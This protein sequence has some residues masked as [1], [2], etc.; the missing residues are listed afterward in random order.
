MNERVT[1]TLDQLFQDSSFDTVSHGIRMSHSRCIVANGCFD[2]LHPGHLSLLAHLDTI[3]YERRLRP[4]VALNSDASIR[5]LKG[6][7]RPVVQQEARSLLI[8]NLKWPL[9]VVIFDED[10][11]QRLMDLL[12]PAVVLKGAEYAT[13]DVVRFMG[14][15]HTPA[16]EV[17]TVPM[18]ADWSTSRIL[19]DT[20]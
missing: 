18:L 3:A 8:N 19:G 2:V 20:R 10:T 7:G 17:I 12:W 13:T 4:I 15:P 6:G 1:R 14:G 9:T 16:S 5:R 11:P